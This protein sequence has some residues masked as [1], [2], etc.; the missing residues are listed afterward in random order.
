M[1]KDKPPIVIV[2]TIKKPL[3]VLSD[4]DIAETYPGTKREIIDLYFGKKEEDSD[5]E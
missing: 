1:E 2:N 3:Q 5:D 4:A